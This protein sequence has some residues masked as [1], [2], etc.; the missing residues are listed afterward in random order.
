[1]VDTTRV[2]CTGDDTYGRVNLIT[3]P[4]YLD[5]LDPR[6]AAD[7]LELLTGALGCSSK[8]LSLVLL[9]SPQAFARNSRDVAAVIEFLRH[10][11][12]SNCA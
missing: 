12:V 3:T 5:K 11:L 8:D 4:R 7:V 2:E 9:K 6:R 1:M 10:D